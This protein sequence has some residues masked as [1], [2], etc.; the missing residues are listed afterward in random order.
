MALHYKLIGLNLHVVL[1]NLFSQHGFTYERL[2]SKKLDDMEK[3]NEIMGKFRNSDSGIVEDYL[4]GL[5]GLP[6]SDVVKIIYPDNSWLAV[7]PS[8]T[9]PKIKFY[10]GASG[11]DKEQ[12]EARLRELEEIVKKAG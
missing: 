2:I 4:E 11:I 10:L 8:G 9:E 12:A 1:D 6:K 3:I 5:R 7:R